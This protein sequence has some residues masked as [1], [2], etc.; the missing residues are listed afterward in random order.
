ML[1]LDN[2]KICI[3]LPPK[4]GTTSVSQHIVNKRLGYCCLGPQHDG[5][6]EKHTWAIPWHVNHYGGYKFYSLIRNPYTRVKSLYGHYCRWWEK[7]KS[8]HHFLRE[9]VIGGIYDFYNWTVWRMIHKTGKEVQWLHYETLIQDLSAIGIMT[10]GF[11]HLN[12]GDYDV[13]LT[14]DDKYLIRI[15]GHDDFIQGGYNASI[16]P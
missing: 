3:F 5:E 11:P 6:I 9:I 1:V 10:D 13:K 8:F 4:C 7:P 2:L 16:E 14:E 12:K 15:W